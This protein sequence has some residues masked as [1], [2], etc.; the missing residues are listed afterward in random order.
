MICK[1]SGKEIKEHMK[2]CPQCGNP[3]NVVPIDNNAKKKS[4]TRK[5][6]K[7]IFLI[8][9]GVVIIAAVGGASFVALQGQKT[10][11][12]Y[13]A[14]VDDGNKYLEEMDY[15]KAEASYLKAI[16]IK[17]KE[18]ESYMKLADIY[19]AQDEQDKATEILQQAVENIDEKDSADVIARYNLYSYVEKVLIPQMGK[20]EEGTYECNYD[21]WGDSFALYPVNTEKGVMNWQIAD[22][23]G[24]GT[25]ELLVLVLDNQQNANEGDV[26]PQNKILLQM[27]ASE[28]NEVSLKDEYEGLTPV[29]GGG[30]QEDDGIFL[31]RKDNLIYICGSSYSAVS[32]YADGATVKSFILSYKDGKFIQ[33][34][35]LD[36]ATASSTAEDYVEIVDKMSE[37]TEQLGLSN[38][39]EQLR[40]SGWPRFLFSDEVD[41]MLLR[42]GG[43]NE[44]F[45]STMFY[46]TN[47]IEYLGKVVLEVTYGKSQLA[48]TVSEQTEEK[49]DESTK[50]MV[51]GI[52]IKEDESNPLEMC[53]DLEKSGEVKYYDAMTRE[54][55][56]F[57]RYSVENNILEI[58]ALHI[59]VMGTTPLYYDIEFEENEFTRKMILSSNQKN[60]GSDVSQ[61]FMGTD[62]FTGTYIQINTDEVGKSLGIPDDVDVSVEQSEVQ[63]W[64]EGDLYTTYL[65]YKENGE[66]VASVTVDALTGEW[67][68]D[69]FNYNK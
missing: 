58:N 56:M 11:K 10:E 30:D 7:R 20:V 34:A 59:D 27:Y 19:M 21:Y 29:L 14:Y 26:I 40:S 43:Y 41:K 42:I 53:F 35:G 18:K 6:G 68:K 51:K 52:W 54:N 25:E 22:Y 69:I 4:K 49:S 23:D 17:P 38:E 37:L 55:E 46:Q 28:G 36:Q 3:V 65:S 2:F 50:E 39:T 5:K 66:M 61:V 24:D 62:Y 57:T 33:E 64:Q 13:T 44:G 48:S 9:A 67:V 31:K 47:Q 16:R 12:Q 32:H 60:E 8:I 15:E 63:Y 1:K 45:D